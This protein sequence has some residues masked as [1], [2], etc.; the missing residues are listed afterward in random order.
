[1]GTTRPGKVESSCAVASRFSSLRLAITTCAPA[2][3][4][5]LAIALPMPR[6]PPVTTA[7]RPVRLIGFMVDDAPYSLDHPENYPD[8]EIRVRFQSLLN[9]AIFHYLT[10]GKNH[11]GRRS[12]MLLEGKNGL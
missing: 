11:R 7:T 10:S 9:R 3:A 12:F 5:R 4:R 8:P 2:S 6:P 1:M